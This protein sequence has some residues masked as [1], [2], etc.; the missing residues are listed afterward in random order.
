MN[1]EDRTRTA[2]NERAYLVE[3]GTAVRIQRR[4]PGPIER[5]WSYLVDDKKRG[6]WFASGPMEPRVGGPIEFFFMH[7]RLCDVDEP[8]PEKYKAME[9]GL[10][11]TGKVVRFDPPHVL[12]FDWH[13]IE[14][15]GASEVTIELTAEGTDVLLTLTHRRLT[16][17]EDRLGVSG[18]W[19]SHLSTLQ[20]ELEGKPRRP[21]WANHTA[22]E[23]DYAAHPLERVS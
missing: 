17:E 20:D 4:L 12:A 2:M 19:Q 3:N 18:G 8:T 23:E 16:S 7:S 1:D 22:I 13:E 15:E 9:N 11:S 21:F 10:T 6:R 14:S 5:V